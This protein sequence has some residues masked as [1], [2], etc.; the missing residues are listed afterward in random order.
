[1]LYSGTSGGITTNGV[2]QNGSLNYPCVLD[3]LSGNGITFKNYNFHCPADYSILALFKK[4][5]TGGPNNELNQSMSKFF[6]D[7]TNNTLPQVSFITEAPPYD[8]HPTANI[9]IGENMIKSIVTAVQKSQ[10]WA[11]TAILITYDEGGGFFDH[12]A[13]TQLDAFG[14]AS[15]CR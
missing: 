5:A 13:P 12:H 8:E 9:H 1:M 6:S 3:L 7:C 2:N 14:P 4:W 10:A 15:A 11:S